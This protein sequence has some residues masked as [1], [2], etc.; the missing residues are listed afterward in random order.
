M[1]TVQSHAIHFYYYYYFLH[2]SGCFCIQWL[3]SWNDVNMCDM[4]RMFEGGF[5]AHHFVNFCDFENFV[6]LDYVPKIFVL[7]K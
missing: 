7:G 3:D 2:K 1:L 6:R 5:K 4:I